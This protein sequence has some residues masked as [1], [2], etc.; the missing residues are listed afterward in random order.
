MTVSYTF[1]RDPASIPAEPKIPDSGDLPLGQG[2]EQP[3]EPE[4]TENPGDPVVPEE[5]D[6]VPEEPGEPAG[7]VGTGDTVE[8]PGTPPPLEANDIPPQPGDGGP[9]AGELP[10]R[11]LPAI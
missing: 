7:A 9:E 2:T 11:I 5:T 4:G 10:T 3:P 6:V 1:A 8:P